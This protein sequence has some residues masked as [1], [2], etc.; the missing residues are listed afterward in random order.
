MART[1]IT[2][3]P[4]FSPPDDF[5]LKLQRDQMVLANLSRPLAAVVGYLGRWAH[6]FLTIH[7]PM[8]GGMA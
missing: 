5:L 8:N 4:A 6:F 1:P 2:H 3:P 7:S